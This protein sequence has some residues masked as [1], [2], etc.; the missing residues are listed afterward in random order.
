MAPSSGSLP[1]LAWS[2]FVDFYLELFLAKKK[3]AQL[4]LAAFLFLSSNGGPSQE[5]TENW[6][7]RLQLFE[8]VPFHWEARYHNKSF[9]EQKYLIEGLSIKQIAAE[10]ISSKSTVRK[11]LIN[12]GIPLREHA[13]PH[14]RPSQP[15]YGQKLIRGN[16][17]P[18]LSEARTIS[19]VQELRAE[20]LS[21]RKI[22]ATLNQRGIPTK[23]RG[24]R[25]HAETV[26]RVLKNLD[27]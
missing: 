16:A 22:A 10:I 5:L 4:T 19:L 18:H 23:N 9:L 27:A 25:W 12:F 17:A 6:F 1:P 7:P 26:S 14:G 13:Q 3:A 8:I 15:R 20:K 21:L 11:H 2:T 24:E